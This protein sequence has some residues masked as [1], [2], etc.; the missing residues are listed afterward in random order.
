VFVDSVEA[1]V[2]WKGMSKGLPILIFPYY[3][4]ISFEGEQ[5]E[6]AKVKK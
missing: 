3:T 5:G 6:E 1:C 2:F 4:Y